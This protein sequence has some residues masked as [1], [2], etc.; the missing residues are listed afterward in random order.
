MESVFAAEFSRAKIMK[1]VW[2]S[3]SEVPVFAN[4]IITVA[5]KARLTS[6]AY[7]LLSF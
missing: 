7:L 3:N 1:T 5:W 2:L 6:P 4:I